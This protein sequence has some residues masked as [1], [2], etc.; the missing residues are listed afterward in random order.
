MWAIYNEEIEVVSF[1]TEFVSNLKK[2]SR[3]EIEVVSFISGS[4]GVYEE[5]EDTKG[6]IRIRKSKKDRQ[7][8][9]QKQKDK[10]RSINHTHKTKD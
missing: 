8:N 3:N 1:V 2:L 5:F 10:Q 9:G 4:L 6:M 7:H